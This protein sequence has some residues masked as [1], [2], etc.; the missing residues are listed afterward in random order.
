MGYN[1]T[2]QNCINAAKRRH[3]DEMIGQNAWTNWI[4]TYWD[5][6]GRMPVCR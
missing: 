6:W 1:F 2:G 5:F 4:A 3:N